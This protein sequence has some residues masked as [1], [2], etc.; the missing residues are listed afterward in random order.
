MDIVGQ[1]SESLAIQVV[2]DVTVVTGDRQG[3]RRPGP[4][5]SGP[6]GTVR[7]ASPRFARSPPRP[8]PGSGRTWA[9]VK[10]RTAAEASKARSLA[11]DLH[12]VAR[13]AQVRQMRLL[14]PAR[15]H[16][17][18]SVGNSGDDHAQDIVTVRRPEGVQVVEHQHERHRTRAER[19]RQPRG[20]PT[21]RGDAEP[22]HVGDQIGEIRGDRRVRRGHDGQQGGGVVVEPVERHPGDP[23]GFRLGP[24]RQQGRLAVPR[25]RGDADDAA[26]ARASP[27][28]QS[29]RLTEPAR[30]AG[31]AS[32][33]SSSNAS[34]TPADGG[35]P[36]RPPCSPGLGP[37][38]RIR[39]GS[40]SRGE[41]A[42]RVL[43]VS[44]ADLCGRR[45][46]HRVGRSGV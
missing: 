39:H 26:A 43:V 19:R 17:L 4:W 23:S 15:R 9:W 32:F 35:T 41:A 12:G 34:S 25:R 36:R 45:V 18:G 2:G 21:Q 27:G 7:P 10:T 16:H 37:A 46:G 22:A 28:D 29:A 14:G 13:A 1:L 6:R 31:T 40:E 8:S 24:L 44:P 38:G 42:L 20:G 5:R 33:A 3:S 11:S 30:T